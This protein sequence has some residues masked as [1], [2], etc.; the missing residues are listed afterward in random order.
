MVNIDNLR[1]R[2]KALGFNFKSNKVGFLKL[3]NDKL[4]AKFKVCYNKNAIRKNYLILKT[5]NPEHPDFIYKLT[6]KSNDRIIL[7]IEEY[8]TRDCILY[9]GER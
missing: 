7:F 3:N 2:L 5:G 1:E 9:G 6:S 8:I 4:V